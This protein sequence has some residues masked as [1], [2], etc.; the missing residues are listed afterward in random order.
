MGIPSS[1]SSVTD[2]TQIKVQWTALSSSL[3]TGGS[4]VTS[5][6]L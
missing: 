5:Y 6:H 3:Q 2:E 4:S 1:D